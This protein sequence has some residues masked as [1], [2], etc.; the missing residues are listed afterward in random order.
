[1]LPEIEELEG[2]IVGQGIPTAHVVDHRTAQQRLAE[3]GWRG[4][5]SVLRTIEDGQGVPVLAVQHHPAIAGVLPPGVG[6]MVSPG[7]S[8]MKVVPA[9]IATKIVAQITIVTTAATLTL[10]ELAAN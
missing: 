1:M 4:V 5:E 7:L 8:K 10:V 6:G 9:M 2:T 3:L